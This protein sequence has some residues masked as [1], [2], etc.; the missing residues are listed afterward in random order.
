MKVCVLLV[1]VFSLSASASEEIFSVADV[2]S[3]STSN[4]TLIGQVT[5]LRSDSAANIEWMNGD[6]MSTD[7]NL[8]KSCV[9][10]TNW[11]NSSDRSI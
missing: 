9:N 1:F 3:C 11:S 2:V 8:Q 5:S 4:G 10:I 6:T 7:F